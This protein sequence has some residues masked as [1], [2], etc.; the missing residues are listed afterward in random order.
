MFR[1]AID[2]TR[3]DLLASGTAKAD[4]SLNLGQMGTEKS[5]KNSV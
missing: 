1:P 4:S 2:S 3:P 5:S